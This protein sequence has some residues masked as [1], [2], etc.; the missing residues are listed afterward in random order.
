MFI[1]Y[2]CTYVIFMIDATPRTIN[3]FQAV[4]AWEEIVHIWHLHASYL[5]NE[6]VTVGRRLEETHRRLTQLFV[7]LLRRLL[8]GARRHAQ[9]PLVGEADDERHLGQREHC[10]V[11]IMITITTIT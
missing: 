8:L 2:K 10:G 1:T 4:R 6:R 9:G 7:E 5:D 11:I 3:L